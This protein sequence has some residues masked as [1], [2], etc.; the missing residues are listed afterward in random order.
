ML[1]KI[2]FV[3]TRYLIDSP[4]MAWQMWGFIQGVAHE[5]GHKLERDEQEVKRCQ[6]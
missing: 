6:P 4:Q 1:I 5:K 3:L 2:W